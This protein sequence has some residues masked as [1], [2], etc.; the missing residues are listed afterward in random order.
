MFIILN[1][2]NQRYFKTYSVGKNN[3]RKFFTQILSNEA[4][5]DAT[6]FGK[7]FAFVSVVGRHMNENYSFVL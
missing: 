1:L 6:Q 7:Q 5:K 2:M 4:V 3:Y